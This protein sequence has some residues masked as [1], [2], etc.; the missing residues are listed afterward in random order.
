MPPKRYSGPD[1]VD[2]SIREATAAT[3]KACRESLQ[4]LRKRAL[5]AIPSGAGADWVI[6]AEEAGLL[7]GVRHNSMVGLQTGLSARA[8]ATLDI[9]AQELVEIARIRD[10]EASVMFSGVR[11]FAEPGMRASDVESSYYEGLER[12]PRRPR[13]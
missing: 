12:A 13:G 11:L 2:R 4:A 10:E 3:E 1:D 8:G 6:Y 7:V 5:G 9:V